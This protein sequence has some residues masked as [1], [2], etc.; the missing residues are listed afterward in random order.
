MHLCDELSHGLPHMPSRE[1]CYHRI[2]LPVPVILEHVRDSMIPFYSCRN[3]R[4]NK[5]PTCSCQSCGE[6]DQERGI[7]GAVLKLKPHAKRT[8]GTMDACE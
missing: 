4:A 6:C 8:E 7:S 5:E 1:L 2:H 3:L